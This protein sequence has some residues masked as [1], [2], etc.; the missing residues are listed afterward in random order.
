MLS[1]TPNCRAVW[2]VTGITAE[3]LD[4]ENARSRLLPATDAK[5]QGVMPAK[6]AAIRK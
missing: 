4:V 5:R 2:I 3:E 6:T 1:G